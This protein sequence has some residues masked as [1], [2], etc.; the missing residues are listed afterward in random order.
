MISSISS[1][2]VA[3]A[4]GTKAG[5]AK[6]AAL[7]KQAGVLRQ[8]LI[9]AQKQG[10]AAADGTKSDTLEQ[11]IVSVQ[12]QIE[13]LILEAQLAKL[14]ARTDASE[15]GSSTASAKS[16]VEKKST[17]KSGST[18]AVN[19]SDPYQ[20]AKAAGKYVNIRA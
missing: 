16:G 15:Q 4:A 1:S 3:S 18:Q 12:F 19:R 14:G 6:I 7:N 20:T 10:P 5:A 8:Q 2:F 13:Q 11:Q 17:A 9:Q